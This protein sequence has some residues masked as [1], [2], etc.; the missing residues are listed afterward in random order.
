MNSPVVLPLVAGFVAIAISVS[1][2]LTVILLESSMEVPPPR[3]L[4][5]YTLGGRFA[6]FVL[7]YGLV[8]GLAYWVG[9]RRDGSSDDGTLA[10]STGVVA[11]LAHLVGAGAILASL[12]PGQDLAI[13]ALATVGSSVAV[14]TQL[15]VVAFAGVALARRR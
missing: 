9:R 11:A 3:T 8:L 4:S 6:S 7:V 1:R 12:E 10:L 5:L 13:A 15:A 14:G 2:R